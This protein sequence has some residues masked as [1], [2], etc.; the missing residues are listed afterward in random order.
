MFA[1]GT[2][3][4]KKTPTDMDATETM[5][6]K[7]HKC[8]ACLRF[9]MV[10]GSTDVQEMLMG[11]LD[12]CLIVLHERDKTACIR[13]WKKTLEAWRVSELPRDFTDFYND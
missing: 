3:F 10:H 6:Y 2:V 13:N 12:H 11:L 9:K 5:S 8:V 7:N 1:K 4:N